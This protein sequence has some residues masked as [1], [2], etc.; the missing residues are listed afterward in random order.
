MFVCIFDNFILLLNVSFGNSLAN[1]IIY[2]P[3]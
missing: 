3:N 2:L 1:E